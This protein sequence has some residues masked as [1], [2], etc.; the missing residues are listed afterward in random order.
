MLA[1][2][3]LQITLLYF[4][5]RGGHIIILSFIGFISNNYCFNYCFI[6]HYLKLSS[7]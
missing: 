4:F 5:G 6:F 7:S 2:L 1:F 3:N